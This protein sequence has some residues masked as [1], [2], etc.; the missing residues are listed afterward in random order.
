MYAEWADDAF[1][2]EATD[3]CFP[4]F[5][6][7]LFGLP[8]GHRPERPSSKWSRAQSQSHLTSSV[9]VPGDLMEVSIQRTENI[10]VDLEPFDGC[11]RWHLA[12][13]EEDF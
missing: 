11:C 5:I 7:I 4:Y 12:T 2:L 6:I 9:Y 3:D 1:Q 10:Q 8:P 13:E